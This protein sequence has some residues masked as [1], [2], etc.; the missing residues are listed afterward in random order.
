[1][2]IRRLACTLIALLLDPPFLPSAR[3]DSDIQKPPGLYGSYSTTLLPNGTW[4]VA[5]GFPL[6]AN[7]GVTTIASIYDPITRAW[8]NTGSMDCK[9]AAHAATLLADGKV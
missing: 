3:A 9:R 1:M 8:T 2:V 7:A 4:L 5:G 6:D